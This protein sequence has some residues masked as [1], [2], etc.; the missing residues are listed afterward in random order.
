MILWLPSYPKSGNTWLRSF[1]SSLIFSKN[2]EADFEIIK[3][4]SQYPRR[5]HFRGLV[6]DFDDI[7]SISENWISSQTLL[8]L[9]NKIKFFKTHHVMCNFGKN[10]FTNYINSAGVIYIVRDPRNVITSICNHYQI[11]HEQ[12][13][14]FMKTERKALFSKKE[15]RFLAFQPILSWSLNYKSWAENIKYPI[16]V[17]KYEDLEKETYNAFKKTLKFIKKISNSNIKIDEQKIKNCIISC[18]FEKLKQ[19]E[20]KIGFN[21]APKIKNSDERLKFFHLGKKNIWKDILNKNIVNK[22]EK[23][24][25]SEMKELGYL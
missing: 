4:I 3:K 6:S 18:E 22:I 2:G 14:E 24:F 13:L 8:N 19:L 21:E 17:V 23:E 12:A 10:S 7:N 25:S 11:S 16:L 20:N 9:D 5:S 1:L 15:G